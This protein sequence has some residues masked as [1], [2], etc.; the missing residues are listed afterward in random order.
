SRSGVYSYMLRVPLL[1]ICSLA[2]WAQ[3]WAQQA[4]Q[5][6]PINAAIQ[7]IWQARN[8]GRFE[9]AAAAREQ[10]RS[11][12]QRA[13]VDAPQFQGWAQQVSQAYQNSGMNGQARAVLQDALARTAVLGNS[14]PAH[15]GMLIALAESWWQDGSLLKAAGYLEQ[16]AAAQE[17]DAPPPARD[18]VVAA[19]RFMAPGGVSFSRL[20]AFS[21]FGPVAFNS[22]IYTYTRLADLYRQLGRP[23]AVAS[24]AAKIRTLSTNDPAAL[25]RFYEQRGQLDDAAAIYRKTAEQSADPQ[26]QASAWQALAS[27]DQRQQRYSDAAAALQQA[28]T[29]MESSDK[30]GMRDQTQWI[31]QSL[32]RT[33]AQ[34]G[35][36]DQ[37]DQIF[38][39]LIQ[40]TAGS[41]QGGQMLISY[42]Q[43]LADTQRG[44][45]AESLLKES[46]AEG[47]AS[48]DPQQQ[49]GV[50]FTLANLASRS[51]NAKAAESYRKE[52]QALQPQPNPPAGQ[53]SLAEDIRKIN[54]SLSQRQF[55]VASSLALHALDTAPQAADRYQVEWFIPNVATQLAANHQPAKAEQLFQRLFVLMESWQADSVQHLITV[56]QNYAQFLMGQKDRWGDVPAALEQYRDLLA[57]SYGP[58]SG[59]LAQPLRKKLEFE[60][61]HSQWQ[62]AQ[63]SGRE[64]LELQESLSGNTSEPYL[65]DLQSVAR[66]YTAAGDSPTALPLFRKAIAIADLV[67]TPNND[68]SRPATRME[69]AQT[70]ANLKQFDEAVKLAEEAV[71][72]AKA[73][74]NQQPYLT[75]QLEQLREMQQAA[76]K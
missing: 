36:P 26:M 23:D 30:P 76:A 35:Q 1:L 66:A 68:W 18:Q 65:A 29:V 69:A 48:P 12:L 44:S 32:A 42:A 38:Q 58:D 54:A 50:Y 27:L 41:P 14:H 16:A 22:S 67:S 2:A 40:Q 51:G 25:A 64:L 53:Q 37:G 7:V 63:A 43:Y 57:S 19:G 61:S 8:E 70:L 59:A 45:Q 11:L 15:A 6:D 62:A 13:P 46:L 4:P 47:S 56:S 71:A 17:A 28:L 72:V 34:A 24:V 74:T 33:L 60:R 20:V 9:D 5:Q 31:R 52:A 55:E 75:Q 3:H 21:G 10:A 39:Q 73:S 49:S